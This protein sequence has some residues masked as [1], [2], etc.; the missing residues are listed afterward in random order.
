MFCAQNSCAEG[1][2]NRWFYNIK[3]KTP[4]LPMT[5]KTLGTETQRFLRQ[6]RSDPTNLPEGTGEKNQSTVLQTSPNRNL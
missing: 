5:E 3:K 1:F 6:K 2:F 4:N